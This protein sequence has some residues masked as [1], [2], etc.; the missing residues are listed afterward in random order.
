MRSVEEV[1]TTLQIAKLNPDE[2]YP[3]TQCL[4]FREHVSS[5]D[6]CLMELDETLCKYVETGKSLVIRGDKNEH[7]VLCSA[8]ETYELKIAD[9]SNLLLFIPNGR[10]LDNLSE[11]LSGH[12][13]IHSQVYGFSNCYWELRKC[14]PKLKK[15]K[16]LLLENQYEGLCIKEE[17]SST[18]VPIS[19]IIP[20]PITMSIE[21]ITIDQ[22]TITYLVVSMSGDTTYLFHSLCYILHGHIRLT[23]DIRRNI[24]SYVLNDWHRFKVWTDDGTGDKY[25]TQEHYKSEMLKPFTYGSACLA[26][27]YILENSFKPESGARPG[28]PKIGILITDGKSQDDVIPP[29]RSLQD[30]GI[31]LFA[32]GVKNADENELKAIASDP[33]DSHVYNVADFNI[34]STIVESLTKTVCDRVEEQDKKIKGVTSSTFLMGAPQDLKT[35]EVTARSF[36]VTWAH[37]P[38]KVEKYR[39]VFYPTRGGQPEEAVVDGSENTVVLKNLMSL[40]EYQIAVFAVYTSTASEGLRGS[41]TTLALPM[42]SD[43]HLYDVT[44]NSMRV[45]WKGVLGASGYMILYAP[46]TE[47]DV[48]DEKEV[49]VLETITDIELSGLTPNTEYTVTVYAMYGE[50]ASDPLTGQETT[51][52]LSAP[53]NLK[54][55]EITHNGAR[56]T[57][58]AASKK[59]KGYKI[60]YVKT[61]GAH[62]N[63]VEVGQVTTEF[64][65]NLSSLTEY[66]VAIFSIYDEGQS[67]PL[68]GAF[69]TLQVP[70]PQ[71]LKIS[72]ETTSSFRVRWQNAGPDIVLYKLVWMPSASSDTKELILNGNKDTV[73]LNNLEPFTEYEVSLSAIYKD[74]SESDAIF[75]LGMTLIRSGVRNLIV[76]DETTFSMKVSWDNVDQNVRQYRVSYVTARGDRAEEVIMV[77]GRQNNILLQPLLS[78]TEYKI[79]VIPVYSDG[80]GLSSSSIGRTLYLGVTNLNTYQVRTTSMCVQWQPHRNAKMYRAVIENQTVPI[81]TQ[82]PTVPSTTTAIPTI[83][84]AREIC[85]AAKADLVFLVDGSWSIGDDNFHKII[86]FL[87]STSGAL[88]QI[89]PEGTQVAIAQYSDDART[90]FKLNTYS[91]KEALLEAIQRI[92]YKGGNTKTGIAIKH[93]K[94]TIYTTE[95]GL[96]RGI[97][98]VLVVLTDGRSQDDVNKIS[99]ELQMDGYVIFAIGFADADYGELIHIASKPSDRHVFFVDDLD[100][101]K[102][103]EEQLI[104]FVC[105]AAS[106]TCPSVLMNGN[107]LAGFRMMEMFGL[108]ENQ[109]ASIDGISMEPGTFNSFPC[110]RLHKDALISQP[111]K[112]LHPE[113][114]PSEYTITI[115]FRLLPETPHEPFALW[116]ILNEDKE[117]LVG[118]ILDNGGETLTFFNYDYKGEFQTVTFEGPA[119]KKIFYGSFHKLHVAISKTSAKVV[120]DCKQVGEKTINAAGNITID[121]TEVLGRMVRSRGKKDNSAPFQLQMFDIVCSSSWA[122][123][124]KCCEIPGLHRSKHNDP[125]GSPKGLAV[126]SDESFCRKAISLCKRLV[127]VVPNEGSFH[128]RRA[129]TSEDEAWK[130]YLENPLTAATKAMMSIN[131]DEDSAAALG[132]LYDYY[133]VPKEKRLLQLNK[134]ID[135]QDGQEKRSSL[136]VTTGQND[137]DCIDNRVQVLKSLPVNLSLNSDHLEPSKREH[138]SPHMQDGTTGGVSAVTVVKAEVYAPVFMSPGVHYN[139]GDGEEQ[140]RVIFEQ[141]QYEVSTVSHSSYLKDDQRSTP[142]STY[143]ESFKEDHEKYRTSSLGAEEFVFEPPGVDSFQYMLEATKSLRQKQGEGPMTYLNKGQFYAITLSETGA[144]KGLRHPISKVRSVI[145]VVFSE[146]KNRD[147]Q[148]KYW[149]YWHSRQHTAKQRVLD[150]GFVLFH[151]TPAIEWREAAPFIL[152]RTC[153]RCI[154]V[155]FCRHFLVWRKRWLCTRKHSGCPWSSSPQHFRRTQTRALLAFGRHLAVT[156]CPY[157]VELPCSVPVVPIPNRAAALS[158]SGGGVPPL[159]VLPGILAGYRPHTC[160]N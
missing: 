124:D 17:H 138:Y 131:G 92:Q 141:T 21:M 37:A 44:H 135:A 158:W 5:G 50:E 8:D 113:G 116:E 145:M 45:R 83:P 121:G 15:L 139:R 36:R 79:T 155:S 111:T 146:D 34:M 16:K 123:R 127:V 80:D 120:I 160:Y 148:L 60:M 157:R 29:A 70:T 109:Y 10:T 102:K 42:V 89:G 64:L 33:D 39:V 154:P 119:I 22:R 40:T 51:L 159:S 13:I 35:S 56:V 4:S 88:D 147:E 144:N 25:T 122:N 81:P 61:D 38:G 41:E 57:W 76:T 24:V 115:L 156:T 46:L 23:L 126:I 94:D 105:E 26:L 151:P 18:K 97:P 65:K 103:I 134:V 153:S 48:T 114:L 85:K 152:T 7:A 49:K 107:T 90:E 12:K 74:E 99:K 71:N 30:A 1:Q 84:A 43:L 66:T 133:K 140:P 28:V 150:I 20:T 128:S 108:V 77:P 93:V 6:F 47:A 75:A 132:L 11:D 142:D 96:R 143:D 106:A 19:F 110:Y 53:R 58:D 104:T 31:E 82:P 62:T 32:I 67:E 27:T 9:T 59:V 95:G 2:F 54:F 68:T 91:D 72:E 125:V 86:R 130:S 98:K 129:Y 52:P 100:A 117:P 112:Y 73:I 55:S 63:E 3:V 137:L 118:I 78:D 136:E 69:T 87:Y 149:K 101:F 14:R